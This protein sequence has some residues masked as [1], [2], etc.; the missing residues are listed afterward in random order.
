MVNWTEDPDAV[1]SISPQ[2]IKVAPLATQEF[3][4]S[5][6]P[7]IEEYDFLIPASIK[8]KKIPE[9]HATRMMFHIISCFGVVYEK[10][11]KLE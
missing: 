4:V 3:T 11:K 2:S 5:F 8:R 1:F 7:V 10:T 6:S 9:G